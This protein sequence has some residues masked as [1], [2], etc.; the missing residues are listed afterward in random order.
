MVRAVH[1]EPDFT[2]FGLFMV[3]IT[4]T[5]A[6]L[7]CGLAILIGLLSGAENGG[8][9]ERSL[10]PFTNDGSSRLLPDFTT[11]DPVAPLA[12]AWKAATNAPHGDRAPRAKE[13]AAGDRHSGSGPPNRSESQPGDDS[14]PPR[15]VKP[16]P[17]PPQAPSESQPSPPKEPPESPSSS[18]PQTPTTSQPSAPQAPSV[19]PDSPEPSAS[20]S[21]STSPI[22]ASVSVADVSVEAL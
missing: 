19:S 22:K 15:V 20:V 3:R 12:G 7:G 1:S 21:V 8:L 2:P 6:I 9:S 13:Q 14:E 10:A 18:A 4:W 5:T 11:L 17:E 16:R